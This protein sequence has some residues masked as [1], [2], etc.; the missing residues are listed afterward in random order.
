MLP[1]DLPRTAASNAGSPDSTDERIIRAYLRLAVER[2]FVGTTTRAVAEAAGVNEVTIFRRF[3]DKVSLMRA[4]YERLDPE[5]MFA[6]YPL[7]I[8]ASTP[9]LAQEG[10]LRC[11]RF[12]RDAMW[13]RREMLQL[14]LSETWRHPELG[15][16]MGK[17]PAAAR[18]LLERAL[19][20]AQPAFRP[21]VDLHTTTLSL[22]G[23]LL[24]TVVWQSRG[25][26]RFEPAEWDA[27]LAA[28]IRPLFPPS[29]S[30]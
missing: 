12:M 5:P 10:L 21:D 22:M 19:T 18:A 20:Q 3:G 29:A 24:L 14:G 26:L 11:L 8:D 7:A 16:M 2:G 13:E 23:L 25:W 30:T 27:T 9:A 4:L 1:D 6:A 15:A 17:A 28:A